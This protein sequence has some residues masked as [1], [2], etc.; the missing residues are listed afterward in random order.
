MNRDQAS[1]IDDPNHHHHHHTQTHQTQ[2]QQQLKECVE[3]RSCRELLETKVDNGRT[4]L[5]AY[6]TCRRRAESWATQVGG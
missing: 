4:M 3:D 1:F 5:E 6:V 2:P